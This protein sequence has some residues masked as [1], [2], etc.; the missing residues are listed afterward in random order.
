MALQIEITG[1][2]ITPAGEQYHNKM[3][4]AEF[5]LK[6]WKEGDDI[7]TA[8]PVIDKK[9]PYSQ[10][11]VVEGKTVNDL[12]SRVEE[13]VAKQIK[14]EI[15]SYEYAKIIEAKARVTKMADNIKAMV[16]G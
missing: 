4:N 5:Q 13:K 12:A 15:S 7:Q 16:E 3:V 10:K 2:V 14:Q 6:C 11:T 9:F 1:P 8:A